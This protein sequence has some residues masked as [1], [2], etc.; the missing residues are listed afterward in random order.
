MFIII[1]LNNHELPLRSAFQLSVLDEPM[2]VGRPVPAT[3]LTPSSRGTVVRHSGHMVFTQALA[4]STTVV[5]L[6]Q[7]NPLTSVSR[8]LLCTTNPPPSYNRTIKIKRNSTIVPCLL[9]SS[10]DLKWHQ[11]KHPP[12]ENL[13]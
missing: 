13:Q 2:K 3:G 11:R 9:Q 8:F 4:G 1:R 6:E 5:Q 12:W 7:A 10:D